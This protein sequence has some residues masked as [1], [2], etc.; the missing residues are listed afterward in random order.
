MVQ[1]DRF[2]FG[3]LGQKPVQTGLAQ[4]FGLAR[5]FRFGSV[6]F[7]LACFFYL[8]SVR[9]SFFGFRFI[10]PKPNQIGWF[11]QNFNRFNQFFSRFDFFD[12]LFSSFLGFSIFFSLL[13]QVYKN[14]FLKQ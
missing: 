1:T 4:F 11:F 6:F 12:Y 9:F 7:D 3:F 14:L 13:H 5:F 2:Q 10:K 8:G